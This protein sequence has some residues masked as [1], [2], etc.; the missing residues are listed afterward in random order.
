[1]KKIFRL[2][3][4][5][6]FSDFKLERELL[7]TRVFP[8]IQQYCENNGA[9]FQPIDLRW[10]IDQEAQLDQRTM[11]ICLNEVKICKS[12]PYPNFIILSGNRYGW[13]PL[14]LKIEKKEF[15]AIVS[16]IQE[17]DKNL[18][19]QWYFLDENQLDI[20]G[21]MLPTYRLKEIVGAEEW[22]KINSETKQK[23]FD[24]WYETEN[25][26]RQILQTGVVK[27]HLQKKDAEKYFMSATHQE[28]AEYSKN[29]IDKEHIFVFCRDEQQ[30]TNNSDTENVEN[31]RYFIE[32]VLNPDN[33]YYENIE[34]KEYL[35]NFC[36]KV[37]AFLKTKITQQL[38]E[39]EQITINE[40][41]EHNKFKKEKLDTFVETISVSEAI[42]NIVDFA[43]NIDLHGSFLLY[44][45]SGSGKTT[46]MAKSIDELEKNNKRVIYRFVGATSESTTISG[47]FSSIFEELDIKDCIIGNTSE[48]FNK[49]SEILGL[50]NE[51]IIIFIDGIEQLELD[52]M[53]DM[54]F[55][56]KNC[57]CKII[58]SALDDKRYPQESLACFELRK[59]SILSFEVKEISDFSK[60]VLKILK[61][62]NRTIQED[63]IRKLLFFSEG[64]RTPFYAVIA[65]EE[66]KRLSSKDVVLLANSQDY[67]TQEFIENLSTLYHHD[68]F[69]IQKVLLYLAIT[70]GLSENELLTLLNIDKEFIDK[71]AP[72]MF[73]KNLSHD[74][75]LIHYSRFMSAMKPFLRIAKKDDTEV[76]VF[77][78]REFKNAI[79]IHY[80]D[81]IKSELISLLDGLS[82]IIVSKKFEFNRYSIIFADLLVKFLNTG[83]Y[84]EI[85]GISRNNLISND[86][87]QATEWINKLDQYLYKYMDVTSKNYNG[88]YL[89]SAVQIGKLF[90]EFLSQ[91]QDNEK[92]M[93]D[94]A[95]KLSQEAISLTYGHKDFDSALK[96]IED[97]FKIEQKIKTKNNN[98][99]M[100]HFVMLIAKAYIFCYSDTNKLNEAEELVDIAEK[101][102]TDNTSIKNFGDV[103]YNKY[104]EL[105]NT[106]A[107]IY[108]EKKEYKKANGIWFNIFFYTDFDLFKKGGSFDMDD[109]YKEKLE[110]KKYILPIDYLIYSINYAHSIFAELVDT[111]S[112]DIQEQY[113]CKT[114]LKKLLYNAATL[115]RYYYDNENSNLF[116][117]YY[118]EAIGWIVALDILENSYFYDTGEAK[119]YY[120]EILEEHFG[121]ISEKE[122]VDKSGIYFNVL[123]EFYV[124]LKQI[125]ESKKEDFLIK[126]R[127]IFSSLNYSSFKIFSLALKYPYRNND[128]IN[129]EQFVVITNFAV[130]RIIKNEITENENITSFIDLCEYLDN[131]NRSDMTELLKKILLKMEEMWNSESLIDKKDNARALVICLYK[132]IIKHN[133][134]ND[135]QLELFNKIMFEDFGDTLHAKCYFKLNNSSEWKIYR[136]AV[137]LLNNEVPHT[138]DKNEKWNTFLLVVNLYDIYMQKDY[139]TANDVLNI[140]KAFTKSLYVKAEYDKYSEDFAL[141]SNKLGQVM[142][143]CIKKID[144]NFDDSLFGILDYFYC[145]HNSMYATNIVN[146][147]DERILLLVAMK[148]KFD[149]RYNKSLIEGDFFDQHEKRFLHRPYIDKNLPI[150]TEY[151]KFL[152]AYCFC[153]YNNEAII[154]AAKKLLEVC[155]YTQTKLGND[156]EAYFRLSYQM[157]IFCKILKRV[158]S[159]KKLR[160]DIEKE[161]NKISLKIKELKDMGVVGDDC[162]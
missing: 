152:F 90:L 40:K 39:L 46:I 72:E 159:D 150:A 157:D 135:L 137:M 99:I 6:T 130:R 63:Q 120:E 132:Y 80:G 61:S 109:L 73:H 68:K 136:N 69:F 105:Q 140:V 15:E 45:K 148:E 153:H 3:L 31:F 70:D 62:F 4:S 41:D 86:A 59:S 65:C 34:N 67:I 125:I 66:L 116:K 162:I 127:R 48:S 126:E 78:H 8:E 55:I 89:L 107:L 92:Y 17:D 5:S 77:T 12:Y 141:F 53:G 155:Q 121:Y 83:I 154:L 146:D 51:K 20:S 14:P 147:P 110:I 149:E 123:N 122:K 75:P 95:I 43:N 64:N 151:E 49:I 113:S 142:I 38:Q 60:F 18:L 56:P 81:V 11:E 29:G 111:T 131:L 134:Y 7:Q 47:L 84:D 128:F 23:I 74:L 104:F 30:K 22:K 1:M 106:K 103:F 19:H 24:S 98:L 101:Y 27:S 117:N 32:E 94:I 50:L 13:I 58:I 21:K 37:L 93:T 133:L 145:R 118:I 124:M 76:Y 44:G 35:N 115:S 129:S 100:M 57:K 160:D 143:N 161:I 33:I 82:K 119:C 96:R 97:F 79:L 156:K 139:F 9:V 112:L 25:K 54:S 138:C 144:K 108:R 88:I 10:G 52:N 85:L 102:M 158:N 16:N 36:E 71:V 114:L 87:T 91:S 28:V 26:I 42:S 2:F